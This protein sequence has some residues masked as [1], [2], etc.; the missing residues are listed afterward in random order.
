VIQR[1]RLWLR[2]ILISIDQLLHVLLGGPKYLIRGGPVPSADE[3]ISSKVGRR[4]IAGARWA[5]LAERVI[6]WLFVQ[7]GEAPGHCRRMIEVRCEGAGHE[8]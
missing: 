5:M 7:L 6:D 2:E 3:T 8:S 1:L 4:S